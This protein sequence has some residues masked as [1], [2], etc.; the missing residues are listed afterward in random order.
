M[1]TARDTD[2]DIEL[3]R[4]CAQGEEAALRELFARHAGMVF[5]LLYR[6]LG[7]R[8]DADELLPEVFLRVWRGAS[9]FQQRAN[10][11]TWIYRIASNACIDRLRRRPA[12]TSVSLEELEQGPEPAAVLF[13][14][15]RRLILADEWSRLQTGLLALAPEDRLL[16]TL[17]HLQDRSYEEIQQITGLSYARLK[18]R[19]FRARQRLREL[20]QSEECERQDEG[21]PEGSTPVA[22]FQWRS[23]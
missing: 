1:M 10:P 14:P 17:Y 2:H 8:D 4:R 18:S 5:N 16:I 20:Y 15:D 3:I 23:A 11:V 21:V 9:R 12:L 19:L 7:S 6:M 22:R 13:D